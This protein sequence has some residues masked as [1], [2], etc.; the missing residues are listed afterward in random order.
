VAW[1]QG[2]GNSG[3]GNSADR[4]ASGAVNIPTIRL[5]LLSVLR[6]FISSSYPRATEHESQHR[7]DR[8]AGSPAA[9][10]LHLGSFQILYMAIFF[11]ALDRATSGHLFFDFYVMNY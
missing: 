11:S 7:V 10:A 3:D 6:S 2:A 4:A 9:G 5:K 8:G 1:L